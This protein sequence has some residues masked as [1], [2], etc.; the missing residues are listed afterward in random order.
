[1]ELK[2]SLAPDK[3][4]RY[5]GFWY[6]N[7]KMILQLD[8]FQLEEDKVLNIHM[9]CLDDDT[10]N[11]IKK[12]P[13]PS[14]WEISNSE[15]RSALGKFDICFNNMDTLIET[16]TYSYSKIESLLRFIQTK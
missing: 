1:M 7:R 12:S 14:A 11:F 3:N 10:N 13:D 15:K 2:Q 16:M 8:A 4:G 9:E 5:T 6:A